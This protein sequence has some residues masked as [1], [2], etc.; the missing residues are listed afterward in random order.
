[1]SEEVDFEIS[2]CLRARRLRAKKPP[3]TTTTSEH[4]QIEH[5]D[6]RRG[7]ERELEPDGTYEDI[8]ISKKLRGEII[9]D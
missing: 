8:Q 6:Q 2:G 7:H 1:M 3:R 5:R 4:V 9:S